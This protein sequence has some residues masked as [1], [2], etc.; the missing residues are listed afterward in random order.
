[1]Q[2]DDVHCWECGETLAQLRGV[3]L[4]VLSLPYDKIGVG[5]MSAC[6][7]CLCC[8]GFLLISFLSIT[9]RQMQGKNSLD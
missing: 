3:D 9:S 6:C 5:G 7:S 4:L 8:M 1:M 2:S